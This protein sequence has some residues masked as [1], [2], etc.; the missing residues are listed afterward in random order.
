M[1]RQKKQKKLRH[2][3]SDYEQKQREKRIVERRR[4]A[5]ILD[6]VRREKWRDWS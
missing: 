1:G 3:L 2:K 5:K 6:G 4:K